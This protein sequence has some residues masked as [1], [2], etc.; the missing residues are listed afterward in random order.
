M[1]NDYIGKY[2]K[3]FESGSKGIHS[4]SGCGYDWGLSCG[5]YQLTLRW[6]N[7]IN[8]L[9][10]YFPEVARD[11]YFNNLPDV[12]SKTYPGL[13]YCSTIADV[14]KVWNLCIETVGEEKF[15]ELE[16]EHI[17]NT[18]YDALMKKLVGT[19]NPNDHSRALQECLWS[20]SVHK[21]V[22]GAY[23]AFMELA[24]GVN[25][26]TATV[27]DALSF[28]YDYRYKVNATNR[29]SKSSTSERQALLN[30]KDMK[31]L[32]Y[33]GNNPSTGK[34]VTQTT[35]GSITLEPT[36]NPQHGYKLGLYKVTC[37]ELNVRKGPGTNYGI[38][39]V[40]K[41]GDVYTIVDMKGTWG[42][43]KS[44]AGWINCHTKYCRYVGEATTEKVTYKVPFE[45]RSNRTV[46]DIHKTA[47]VASPIS[48][49]ITD[50]LKYT[51]VE[52][53]GNWGRLKSG[54]GWVC[55]DYITKI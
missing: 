29:Y 33:K 31:P 53:K 8:F 6:G 23:K 10:K 13:K 26:Q 21:G 46:L 28:I 48:G 36:A 12:E 54:I 51:I 39:T 37:D 44:G 11:L 38:N 7:C 43:L 14:K 47:S 24:K 50:R 5:T 41:C 20:W 2:V 9:K 45:F 49:Q 3:Q 52:V 4:L 55:L 18:Y 22:G 25:F 30:I 42:K 17:Q 40:V 35:M 27:T 32:T 34:S 15:I 16:H 19:F 1:A